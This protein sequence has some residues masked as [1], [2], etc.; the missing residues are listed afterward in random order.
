MGRN[1]FLLSEHLLVNLFY[2]FPKNL[3]IQTAVIDY[4]LKIRIKSKTKTK[5]KNGTK[6]ILREFIQGLISKKKYTNHNLLKSLIIKTFLFIYDE[7]YNDEKRIEEIVQAFQPFTYPS[8]S[9]HI[10]EHIDDGDCDSI[11]VDLIS[12]CRRFIQ[13]QNYTF[14]LSKNAENE[15]FN[16]LLIGLNEVDQ[17]KLKNMKKEMMQTISLIIR[18]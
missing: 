4:I 8:F 12:V 11:I 7:E 5:L 18:P 16:N 2:R 1:P 10:L 14:K 9:E 13:T 6:M 15:E 17:Q 3:E